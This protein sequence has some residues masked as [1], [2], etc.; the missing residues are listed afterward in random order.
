MRSFGL[1]MSLLLACASARAVPVC[2]QEREQSVEMT[3][4]ASD[5]GEALADAETARAPEDGPAVLP[6]EILPC[7][8]VDSGALGPTCLEASGYL[9]TQGG[10]VLCQVA[11]T[12]D[13]ANFSDP[14]EITD[15]NAPA[16]SASPSFQ[17]VSA[18]LGPESLRAAAP[19]ARTVTSLFSPAPVLTSRTALPPDI[20]S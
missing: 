17:A 3:L 6:V 19:L 15:R 4:T 8:V 7:S 16:G 20:P 13:Y 18:R 12:D 10:Q 5:D 2:E 11:V 9:I 1:L 14:V